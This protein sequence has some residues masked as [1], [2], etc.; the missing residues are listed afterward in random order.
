VKFIGACKAGGDC[1]AVQIVDSAED[2]LD[3]EKGEE[4]KLLDEVLRLRT[5]LVN[6]T[7]TVKTNTRQIATQG[8]SLELK[9]CSVGEIKIML[10]KD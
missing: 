4:E 3:K 6:L 7:S 9:V 1:P 8:H 2:K 5:Q 10:R